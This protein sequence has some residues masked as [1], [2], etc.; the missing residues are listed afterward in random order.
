MCIVVFSGILY[1]SR[2][3]GRKCDH[4]DN[5]RRRIYNFESGNG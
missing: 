4:I 3:S 2:N 5:E 1:R